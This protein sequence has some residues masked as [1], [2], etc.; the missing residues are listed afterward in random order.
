[1][2]GSAA[3]ETESGLVVGPGV[4]ATSAS[5]NVGGPEPLCS[6]AEYKEQFPGSKSPAVPTR[7]EPHGLPMRTT[8]IDPMMQRGDRTF[9][10]PFEVAVRRGDR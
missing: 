10:F 5:S 9:V 3:V 6:A 8:A 2:N 7:R 1:M 4:S